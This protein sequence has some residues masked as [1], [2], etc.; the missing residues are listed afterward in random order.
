MTFFFQRRNKLEPVDYIFNSNTTHNASLEI[1]S[2]VLMNLEKFQ[3]CLVDT[4]NTFNDLEIFDSVSEDTPSVVKSLD[5]TYIFMGKSKLHQVLKNP[6]ADIKTLK[7]LQKNIRAIR[8]SSRYSEIIEYLEI[9]REEEKSVLWLLREKTTEETHIIDQLYFKNRF[10]K[11][12]NSNEVVM[13][14]Y[15]YFR[16]IFAPVYGLLSPIMFMIVPFIYLRIFTGIRIPFTTYLKLFRMTL[17]E[18]Y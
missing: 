8:N 15:N 14:I 18:V 6:L 12:L 4:S 16:I 13:N 1:A 5:K 9:L 10:L 11:H 7:T 2:S 17:F 3:E